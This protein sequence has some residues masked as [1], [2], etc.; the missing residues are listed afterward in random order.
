MRRSLRASSRW[1]IGTSLGI[2][3]TRVDVQAGI[4]GLAKL[5]RGYLLPRF[6]ATLNGVPGVAIGFLER[7]SPSDAAFDGWHAGG[8]DA[9]LVL[10]VVNGEFPIRLHGWKSNSDNIVLM[11]KE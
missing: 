6:Q 3:R 5:E 7:L 10:K 4:T 9:V 8:E 2:D 11:L 1:E